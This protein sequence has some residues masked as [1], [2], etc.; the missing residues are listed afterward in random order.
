MNPYSPP[1]PQ[2]T[3]LIHDHG[4][5]T[6]GERGPFPQPGLA[7]VYSDREGTT[8]A[9]PRRPSITAAFRYQSWYQ[10]DISRRQDTIDAELPSSTDSMRFQLQAD[11]LW[12]VTDPALI[13]RHR[14]TDGL[15]IVRSRLVDRTWRVTR[16][17]DIEDYLAV[18]GFLQAEYERGPVVLSDGITIF[19][20]AIRLHSDDLTAQFQAG[21]R[22]LERT[23][24]TDRYEHDN[25]QKRERQ[26]AELEHERMR[27]L[28]QIAKGED[29]L[30]FVFL[31]RHPDQVGTILQAVAQRREMTQNA[32]L[33]LFDKMVSEGF[34]QEADVEPMRRL[35][36]QPIEQFADSSSMNVLGGGKSPAVEAGKASGQTPPPAQQAPAA[37]GVAGW[38]AFTPGSGDKGS[39]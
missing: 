6:M 18:E 21:R 20:V 4:P 38:K 33:T 13:V 10:V 31:A 32:Q 28:R 34:I 2:P 39:P 9:L 17:Y 36:L 3:G 15:S 8:L 23:G 37:D 30:M 16:R 26:E 35:L 29:D 27:A 14:T 22:Q 1:G 11:V 12:G 25:K 19:N 7:L 5:V 24:V